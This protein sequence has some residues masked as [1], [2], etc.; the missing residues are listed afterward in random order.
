MEIK[1]FVPVTPCSSAWPRRLLLS[2][3]PNTI[4]SCSHQLTDRN[5]QNDGLTIRK[6]PGYG[7]WVG[8]TTT[9]SLVRYCS[10]FNIAGTK[11]SAKDIIWMLLLQKARKVG[12]KKASCG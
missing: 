10:N 7:I 6:P 4:F 1:V 11:V 5:P 9:V 8:R 12:E 3:N 2:D